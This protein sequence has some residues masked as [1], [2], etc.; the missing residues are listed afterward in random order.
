MRGLLWK[1]WK[2]SL[3]MIKV[4]QTSTYLKGYKKIRKKYPAFADDMKTMLDSLEEKPKQGIEIFPNVYKK[5]ISITGKSQGK[6][7]GARLIFY[8]FTTG[9]NVVLMYV[10][11]KA[12]ISDIPDPE[13]KGF[14]KELL[15]YFE[16]EDDEKQE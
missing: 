9:E 13:I 8:Y 15:E 2:G 16:S 14:V 10:Y 7:G 1:K 11:D 3:R 6:S 4:V 12:E 5:R